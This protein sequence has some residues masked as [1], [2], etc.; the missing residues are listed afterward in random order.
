[1]IMN[2][3][4]TEAVPGHPSSSVYTE[5]SKD[6]KVFVESGGTMD[7][8]VERYMSFNMHKRYIDVGLLCTVVYCYFDALYTTKKNKRFKKY[9]YL[10][11]MAV[12]NIINVL[13]NELRVF[14]TSLCFQFGECSQFYQRDLELLPSEQTTYVISAI[15]DHPLLN[16][17]PYTPAIKVIFAYAL[18]LDL[19]IRG[20]K[21]VS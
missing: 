9:P 16:S 15:G 20:E 12:D 2:M 3:T 5:F 14:D 17:F 19:Y 10:Q 8:I 1:M 7:D 21:V 4:Y 13:I 11:A 6:A 18:L